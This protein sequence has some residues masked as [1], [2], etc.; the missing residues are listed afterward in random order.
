MLEKYGPSHSTPQ[1]SAGD[2]INA[3]MSEILGL[4]EENDENDEESN[5]FSHRHRAVQCSADEIQQTI[6]N[7]LPSEQRIRL[8]IAQTIAERLVSA[9]LLAQSTAN[10]S[11]ICL[12]LPGAAV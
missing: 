7:A 8:E 12:L 2:E 10:I 5:T 3:C 1:S 6:W 4:I 11:V 9:A